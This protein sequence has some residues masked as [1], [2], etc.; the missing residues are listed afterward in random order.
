MATE[1][2]RRTSRRTGRPLE[3]GC[4]L[5]RKDTAGQD[6]PWHD[7]GGGESNAGKHEHEEAAAAAPSPP[8]R[9]GAACN[10]SIRLSKNGSPDSPLYG[11]WLR[12]NSRL[13]V[14]H[15]PKADRGGLRGLKHLIT[16][17]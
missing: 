12:R 7:E 16:D 11:R 4:A 2:L 8:R 10:N 1:R 14:P 5:P 6:R 9:E 13:R 17:D 3:A 15:P